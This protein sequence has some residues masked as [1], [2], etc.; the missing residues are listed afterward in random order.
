MCYEF[1]QVVSNEDWGRYVRRFDGK[2][3]LRDKAVSVEIKLKAIFETK[4]YTFNTTDEEIKKEVWE[5]IKNHFP[6]EIFVE[7]FKVERK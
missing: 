5:E 1:G 3:I 4:D 6:D 7:E 2:E